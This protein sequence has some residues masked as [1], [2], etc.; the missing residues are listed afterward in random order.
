M[1]SEIKITNFREVQ[2]VFKKLDPT[3]KETANIIRRIIKKPIV[4]MLKDS[5]ANLV[6]QGSVKS[7]KTGNLYRSLMIRTS[8]KKRIGY[9]SVAFGANTKGSF[10]KAS[11]KQKKSGRNKGFH[12]HLLNSG[13]IN[14]RTHNWKR[15][16]AVGKGKR[17]WKNANKSFRLGFADRAI[18]AHL[19]RVE[20]ILVND[21]KNTYD[22]LVK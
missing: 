7:G 19:G 15:T 18:K 20:R 1:P 6:A 22:K 16:G 9:F 8:F 2:K 13:T 21:L 12:F 14:R 4:P 5:R 3:K 10:K 17:N 11:A